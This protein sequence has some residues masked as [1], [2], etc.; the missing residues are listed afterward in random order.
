MLPSLTR[1]FLD[2]VIPEQPAEQIF[3]HPLVVGFVWFPVMVPDV[4]GVW[5]V[6]VTNSNKEIFLYWGGGKSIIVQH[7]RT[8]DWL[9]PSVVLL[10]LRGAQRHGCCNCPRRGGQRKP[11]AFSPIREDPSLFWLHRNFWET[12]SVLHPWK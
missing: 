11:M 6:I 1:L 2:Q 8:E 9:M 5:L 3:I 4:H 7:Q 10:I 12:R